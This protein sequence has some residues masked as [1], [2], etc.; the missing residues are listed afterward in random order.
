MQVCLRALARR[1][2]RERVH[3][4]HDHLRIVVKSC[5]LVLCSD[6]IHSTWGAATI[7]Y[8]LRCRR[9]RRGFGLGT[10]PDLPLSGVSRLA[11]RATAV[12]LLRALVCLGISLAMCGGM[13]SVSC[14]RHPQRAHRCLVRAARRHQDAGMHVRQLKLCA[15]GERKGR[16]R[17]VPFA[18]NYAQT[19]QGTPPKRGYA[20]S[21]RL[22]YGRMPSRSAS[23]EV[24]AKDLMRSDPELQLIALRVAQVS[25]LALALDVGR[26]RALSAAQLVRA[27]R[28]T[29]G[30]HGAGGTVPFDHDCLAVGDATPSIRGARLEHHQLVGEG[31]E[32]RAGRELGRRARYSPPLVE[33]PHSGYAAPPEERI[34]RP[35]DDGD[36]KHEV[37]E[38]PPKR[39]ASRQ[40]QHEE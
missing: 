35:R 14:S 18:S 15:G 26:E 6:T 17:C 4:L 20:P 39:S 40:L 2:A 25:A 10:T 23:R 9:H 11:K 1:F 30:A 5:I 21:V 34:R 24:C 3:V 37:H 29:T 36:R 33:H 13:L 31:L 22:G 27:E 19:P 16:A 8:W 7:W 38:A 12:S 32:R 28:G